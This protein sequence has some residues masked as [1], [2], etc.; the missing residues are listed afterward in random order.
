MDE[1][2]G[3]VGRGFEREVAAIMRKWNAVGDSIISSF[4]WDALE[5]MRTVDP[6][7]RLGV[8]TEKEPDATLDAA[9]RMRAFSAFGIPESIGPA[10]TK[11]TGRCP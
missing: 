6:G 4:E 10:G 2:A 11:I 1:A 9:A 8:L 5:A 7:I 3:A